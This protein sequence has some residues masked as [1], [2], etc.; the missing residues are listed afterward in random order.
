MN[1]KINIME[2]CG[3]HTMSIFRHGIRELISSNINL[4]SGPGCPVC[5]TPQSYIDNAINISN[6]KN[7]IILTF[8]DMIRVPGKKTSLENQRAMG[9]NLRIVYSPLDCLDI[10]KQNSNKK[11]VFLAVGFE[12]TSPIIALTLK[13]AKEMQINNFFVLSGMKLIIPALKMLC[14]DDELNI[15]GF[16]LP[17]HVSAI[18]G[19]ECYSFLSSEYKIASVIAGFEADEILKSIELICAQ[20]NS[21]NYEIENAYKRVVSKDGNKKAYDTIFEVFEPCDSHWRGLGNI[22]LSG[23]ILK[24]EYKNFDALSQY[25]LSEQYVEEELRGCLCGEVIKG[26]KIPYDCKLFGNSCT[27]LKPIGPCMVSSEGCCSAYYKYGKK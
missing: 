4:I 3:T 6:D 24:E 23:L 12:T 5:V 2:V 13:K 20:V 25:S 19:E 26:K 14:M 9:A 10:A 18:L 17:G 11:I 27:P 21:K 16:L 7:T 22:P 8:G 1:N 15:N